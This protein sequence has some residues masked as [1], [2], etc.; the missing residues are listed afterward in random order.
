[1]P[2]VSVIMP[3]YNCGEYLREAISSVLTQS[4]DDLE[5]IV[6]DGGSRDSTDSVAQS[7]GSDPRFIYVKKPGYG[8]SAA[9]NHGIKIARGEIVA[10]LDG[11]DLFLKDKLLKQIRFFERHG[12]KGICYTDKIYF[13]SATG[14]EMPCTYYPFSGDIFYYLKRN[15]F[16]HPTT[17]MAKR[18]EFSKDLFD[19][20][21]PSH[22]DWELFLRLSA[23]GV[24]FI[25]MNEPLSKI[26][27]RERSV[28]QDSGGMGATRRIV[29]HKGKQYWKEFKKTM[30]FYSIKGLLAVLRYLKFKI[31]AFLIGFPGKECF[32][33]PLPMELL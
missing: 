18:D 32:N 1:M 6:V 22:E 7:F 8:I 26:R 4:Y 15:N 25:F 29:G 19:E 24:R 9:R 13:N 30:N 10:F 33:R 17:V 27:V 11:D 5:L 2:K 21:L 31:G 12:R 20:S 14:K 23:R 3:T 16:I 28:S